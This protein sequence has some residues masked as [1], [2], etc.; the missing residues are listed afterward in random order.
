MDG[1]VTDEF[2]VVVRRFSHV[3]KDTQTHMYGCIQL[4]KSYIPSICHRFKVIENTDASQEVFYLKIFPKVGWKYKYNPRQ[5]LTSS[6][7]NSMFMT[8]PPR[9]WLSDDSY[10]LLDLLQTV[11]ISLKTLW[12]KVNTVQSSLEL[13][14]LGGLLWTFCTWYL[15]LY[16]LILN[17]LLAPQ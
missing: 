2:F 6:V 14:T 13:S 17:M 15:W 10:S 12:I 4:C 8:S 9:P 11:H 5:M 16:I 7:P 3:T 1:I